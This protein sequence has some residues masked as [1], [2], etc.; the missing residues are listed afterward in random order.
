MGGNS[1]RLQ[2]KALSVSEHVREPL[3]CPHHCGAS[4]TCGARVSV[5]LTASARASRCDARVSAI[6]PRQRPPQEEISAQV[7][8]LLRA[9][10]ATFVPAGREDVDVRML[11]TGRPFV[12]SVINPREPHASRC[13]P[14]EATAAAAAPMPMPA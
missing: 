10:G 4:I 2:T 14:S 6:N 12:L 7:L 1:A 8:P 13:A 3:R 5:R 11:G 9:D